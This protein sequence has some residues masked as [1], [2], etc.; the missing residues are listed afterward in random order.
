MSQENSR[1]EQHLESEREKR[2][3]LEE[4]LGRVQEQLKLQEL[5][6]QDSVSFSAYFILYSLT[7]LSFIGSM[8]EHLPWNVKCLGPN[9]Q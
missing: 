4:T 5:S 8:T 6:K 7:L 1:L 9:C 3:H 2:L